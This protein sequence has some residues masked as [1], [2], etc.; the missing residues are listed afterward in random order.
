MRPDI[1][2][3]ARLYQDRLKADHE[4]NTMLAAQKAAARLSATACRR[5]RGPGQLDNRQGACGN[6]ETQAEGNGPQRRRSRAQQLDSGGPAQAEAE[7]LEP[8][9]AARR[10]TND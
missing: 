6:S 1:G 9:S 5:R 4:V 8:A 10:K 2:W 3:H 7:A